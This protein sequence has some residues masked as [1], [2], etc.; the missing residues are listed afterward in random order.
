LH[1]G[2]NAIPVPAPFRGRVE[3]L[4][5]TKGDQV[6]AGEVLCRLT[7]HQD[8]L[9]EVLKALALVGTPDDLPELRPFAHG[10]RLQPDRIRQQAQLT[11]RAIETR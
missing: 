6:T 8:H 7:V 2:A 5:K 3:S 11:I 10:E 9:F 4:T 1:D